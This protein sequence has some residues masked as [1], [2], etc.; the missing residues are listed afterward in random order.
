MFQSKF[1][2][3]CEGRGFINQC[4]NFEEL[5]KQL[6][7]KEPIVA[8]WGTDPTGPSLHVGHLFS[9]MMI[10]LFQQHGNKPI[11]LIGGST[12]LIGDPS[13]KDKSRPMLTRE[14]LLKN[15]EGIIK[16]ISKFIKFGD[17][18]TD[19]ILVD[20]YD[21]WHNK[22]YMEVLREIAPHISVNRMLSFESVKQRL[23][24]EEHMSFLEFNY[25]IL[26]SYDFYHLY[27]K[28]NCTL[29]LCGA[30]QWGNVVAGV[31]LVRRLQ[32]INNEVEIGKKVEV[33]GFSTLLL[34]DSNG[35]KIGKTEGNAIWVNEEL[36]DPFEYFQYFRNINDNDVIKFFKAYTDLSIEKINNL[37]NKDIN[38][39]KKLLAF[40]VTK[41]CHGEE[42][43][44]KCLEKAIKIYEEKSFDYLTILEFPF[45]KDLQL[46]IL[47]KELK[48]I[49]SISEAKRLIK[50]G[51]IKI[52]NVKI[53]NENY[54]V[55]E[56]D[57]QI[58]IGKKKIFRIILK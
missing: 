1:L 14:F 10:R 20:N 29:Q 35:K 46:A 7:K 17:G 26:Q 43:A 22:N 48:I 49:S 32:Y 55:L 56:R 54:L 25:M 45:K 18:P 34:T 42:I 50:S 24:K 19:A 27:K 53:H 41:I 2:Q 58:N 8:Y 11:I 5:D 4:T 52:N 38:E 13:G 47:L 21:W 51:T 31:E 36:L 57:F 33:L 16:S 12:G 37:N 28:Y 39:L 15:K 3:D 30:D 40:E 23:Q 6:L 9:L 44:K